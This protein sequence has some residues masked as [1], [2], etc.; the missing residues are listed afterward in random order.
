MIIII[1]MQ[2]GAL[3]GNKLSGSYNNR[4]GICNT[5]INNVIHRLNKL[6][7]SFGLDFHVIENALIIRLDRN[8]ILETN[9]AYFMNKP[10]T[11]DKLINRLKNDTITEK[12]FT[13]VI[14]EKRHN[15]GKISSHAVLVQID[16]KISNNNH[17]IHLHFIDGNGHDIGNL[18]KNSNIYK[19]F[20]IYLSNRSINESY[21]ENPLYSLLNHTLISIL[22]ANNISVN[23]VSVTNKALSYKSLYNNPL[24]SGLCFERIILFIVTTVH[25]YAK[26]LKSPTVNN[27]MN[28]LPAIMGNS[29]KTNNILLYQ[30]MLNLVTTNFDPKI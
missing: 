9:A 24:P 25:L 14:F 21:P 5:H 4:S 3:Y 17:D 12:M 7:V 16:R 10:Y 6:F 15:N 1:N 13:I 22:S 19:Y 23:S 8:N 29:K 20:Y 18:N 27:V 11:I 2:L 30:S 26:N 28:R